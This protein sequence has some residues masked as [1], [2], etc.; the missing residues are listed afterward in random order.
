MPMAQQ[1]EHLSPI[2][3]LDRPAQISSSSLSSNFWDARDP[4]STRLY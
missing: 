4:H 2:R 3:N 1:I